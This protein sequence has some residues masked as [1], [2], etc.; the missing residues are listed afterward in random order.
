MKLEERPL[1]VPAS[2]SGSGKQFFLFGNFA[3]DTDD[4]LFAHKV[5]SKVPGCHWRVTHV[6]TARRII[7]VATRREAFYFA[8]ESFLLARAVGID[9][10]F[11]DPQCGQRWGTALVATDIVERT[12]AY[13][14]SIACRKS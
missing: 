11:T 2:M 7:D 12:M 8:R 13:R 1:Y 6:N 5:K 9:L 10:N 14:D 3:P 4:T